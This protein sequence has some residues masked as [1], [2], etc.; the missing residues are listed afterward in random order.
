VGWG[1]R[2]CKDMD[3]F[4]GIDRLRHLS[5]ILEFPWNSSTSFDTINSIK[6][7]RASFFCPRLLGAGRKVN[8]RLT[9]V[10]YTYTDHTNTFTDLYT[11]F[12]TIYSN[13]NLI[14]KFIIP[15]MLCFCRWY[16]FSYIHTHTLNMPNNFYMYQ[17]I[18]YLRLCQKKLYTFLISVTVERVDYVSNMAASIS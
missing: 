13:T 12:D 10:C 18:E 17:V 3:D 1:E 5:L 16:I 2:C 8:T 9:C 15:A 14:K 4:T 6:V 11:S 7:D